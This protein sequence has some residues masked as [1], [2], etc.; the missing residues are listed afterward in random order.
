MRIKRKERL[1]RG[2]ERLYQMDRAIASVWKE[3]LY[4]MEE[5]VSVWKELLYQYGKGNIVKRG[6]GD[7]VGGA[8][9]RQHV[10]RE[11]SS[12]EGEDADPAAGW[13]LCIK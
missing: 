1:S 9:I 6:R 3:R 12:G 7:F 4:Q 5:R 2:K 13:G 11:R 10:R 8:S